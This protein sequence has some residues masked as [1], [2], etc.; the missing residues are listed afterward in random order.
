MIISLIIICFI[1][2]VD[3]Q[4][5][6]LV[7]DRQEGIYYVRT[8][9][10]L[11]Y[12][13]SQFIIYR[14]GNDIAYCIEPSK[15]ITTYSY[16]DSDGNINLPY[17]DDVKRK[18]QLIG[19]FGREYPHHDNVHY[20]MAAQ[21]L[22]W[23]LTSNQEIT[24]YTGPHGTG[25]I[26]DITSEKE[27]IMDLV[28]NYQELSL[29]NEVNGKFNTKIEL[30]DNNLNNYTISDY[31]GNDINGN[32]TLKD[33]KLTIFSKIIGKSYIELK[34]NSYDDKGTLIYVGNNKDNS[35]TLGRLR[36]PNNTYRI[37]LDISGIRIRVD[38][39]DENNN[40]IKIPGIKFKIKDLQKNEYL[41]DNSECYYET[42]DDGYFYSK[43][44]PFGKYEIEEVNEIIPGF[45]VNLEKKVVNVNEEGF[46]F[47]SEEYNHFVKTTFKNVKVK[48]K[49]VIIKNKENYA[50]E[51]DCIE[52][53]LEAGSHV[54]FDLFN[55]DN[56][57]I[58][59]IETDDD[60][61]AIIENLELGNYYLKE[62]SLNN[63]KTVDDISFTITQS[64]SEE[65]VIEKEI[66]INNYFEKG[67][68]IIR[69]IDADTNEGIPN[70]FFDIYY[71]DTLLFR[72]K[73]ND[74]GEIILNNMPYGNYYIQEYQAN[75]MYQLTN[76]KYF[77]NLNEELA[78]IIIKNSKVTVDVPDTLDNTNYFMDFS[79]LLMLLWYMIYEKTH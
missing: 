13:S 75:E 24:F 77:L 58:K 33:N 68:I 63:Y 79:S 61:Y 31:G 69:K 47:L 28:N 40:P 21:A 15:N 56:T 44:V 66:V 49:V 29:P 51:N 22:I 54:K 65:K 74:N 23:N 12:Y 71:N 27:E 26:I 19:Y 76:E 73:T 48:G 30:I 39:V 6:N 3:A 45:A 11:P 10:D 41:C 14:V 16:V 1:K 5:Y 60:G 36:L 34:R 2:E 70:T 32:V 62:E 52:Y 46:I 72:K 25:G 50:V 78:N 42:N 59:S 43:P 4:V 67:N 37:N 9:G 35:Q 55:G 18:I 57:F 7:L 20:S 64:N 53:Y 17:S 8:G 38:K